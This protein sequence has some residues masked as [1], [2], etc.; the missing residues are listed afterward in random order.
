MEEAAYM[1]RLELLAVDHPVDHQVFPDDRLVIGGP[2]PSQE[3]LQVGRRFF[4]ERASGPFG[5]VDPESLREIDRVYAYSP[6]KDRRFFGYCEE[7]AL[8]LEFGEELAALE[9]GRPTYLFLG[10]SLEYPYSQ[11]NFASQ[12]A[13]VTWDPP[14]VERQEPDGSWT[15]LVPDAGAPGGMARTIAVDLTGAL[16]SGPVTLRLVTTLELYFDRVFLAQDLGPEGLEVRT[17]P[18]QRAELRRLGFPQEYSPDGRDPR[19]YSYDSIEASF[20]FQRLPGSY[21]RYGDVRELLGDFDDRYVVM[22]TG[23]EIALDF[24][25]TAL[26]E[27]AEGM[28]RTWVLVS[29]AWCKDMDIHSVGPGTVEP[30]PFAGMSG[31]PYPEGESYPW[32]DDARA[33][34]ERY[35]TRVI[36]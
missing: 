20:G 3:L 36:R 17:V 14:R 8:V 30:L 22:A 24:D 16:P 5:A 21:T 26:P 6:R 10:G 35:N 11:T 32:S 23:D 31:Y 15:A 27:P 12:Q 7:H 9:P 28:A 13:G 4:P 19:I 2:P 34:Q 18:L 1:D 29:H 33:W 25:A